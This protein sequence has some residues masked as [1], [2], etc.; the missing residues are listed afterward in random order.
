MFD[1]LK[2]KNIYYT[3]IS[4]EKFQNTKIKEL[5][6]V[7]SN[8]IVLKSKN[9]NNILITINQELEN[10]VAEIDFNNVSNDEDFIRQI[11]NELSEDKQNR[12]KTHLNNM[13]DFGEKLSLL[14]PKKFVIILK[15]FPNKLKKEFSSSFLGILRG[16][17]NKGYA[18]LIFLS[19]G[20]ISEIDD[21]DDNYMGS[22]VTNGI[23]HFEII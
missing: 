6:E 3:Q 13:V 23:S 11:F 21:E 20:Y 7:K 8:G 4:F 5:R 22:F 1:F 10:I 14:Y 16:W 15:N 2:K 18:K 9:F 12:L 17:M 19:K